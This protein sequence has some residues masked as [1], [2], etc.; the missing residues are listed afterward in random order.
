MDKVFIGI[1]VLL[2]I[3]FVGVVLLDLVVWLRKKISHRQ[4]IIWR[5]QKEWEDAVCV[6]AQKWSKKMPTV[7]LKDEE[8]LII[9][10]ILR[11]QYKHSALQGWQYAQLISGLKANDRKIEPITE[12]SFSISEIDDGYAIYHAWKAQLISD[13]TA[14]KLTE[15]YVSVVNKHIKEN[16]LIEY[17]EG[18]GDVYIVDTIAFV[19]PILIR[20]GVI[21]GQHRYIDLAIKQIKN[22]YENAYIEKYGLYAHGYNSVTRTPCESIG[23]GRGTG[24]YLLGILYCYQ[25]LHDGKDKKWIYDRM[26]EASKNIM[27]YQRIDG[28]WS[29]QLV[30][31]WNY[32]SSATAIFATFLFNIYS[33]THDVNCLK[34]GERAIAKL[35]ASTR[36]DG[37]IEYCEGACHGLGKYSINYGISPFAQG[38]VLDMI[39]AYRKI[40]VNKDL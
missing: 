32:D 27:K 40:N 4:V 1:L 8:R 28:G 19:C 38:M 5:N 30:S 31:N 16:G 12:E 29:T 3:C 37:A 11:K 15:K 7:P 17:R 2:E 13:D 18:F 23:W 24:W 9:I 10:D 6:C 26:I 35:M 39:D 34:S 21:T 25:E 36:K 22:Y 14:L 33:I 20:Y